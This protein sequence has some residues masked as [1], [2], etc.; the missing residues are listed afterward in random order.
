MTIE[1]DL[2]AMPPEDLAKVFVVHTNMARA[3]RGM[4]PYTPEMEEQVKTAFFKSNE[5]AVRLTTAA[6]SFYLREMRTR[7]G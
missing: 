4:E 2:E 7:F 6:I 3:I 1:Q 5:G